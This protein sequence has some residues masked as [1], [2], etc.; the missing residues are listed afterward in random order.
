ML[1]GFITSKFK[2]K[3]ICVTGTN[4]KTTSVETFASMSNLLGYKSG[5]MSTINFSKDGLMFEE[6][7]L[8]TDAINT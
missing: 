5:F 2:I 7:D 1:Q 6:S 3:S 8:T 4:G